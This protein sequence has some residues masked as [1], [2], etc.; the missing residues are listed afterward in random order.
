[1]EILWNRVRNIVLMGWNY[2]I[3]GGHVIAISY[4]RFVFSQK[5]K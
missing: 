2:N 4:G 1:M 3:K 5:K